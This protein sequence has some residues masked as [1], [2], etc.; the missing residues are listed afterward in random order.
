VSGQVHDVYEAG[1]ADVVGMIGQLCEDVSRPLIIT[2]KNSGRI[3]DALRN[4]RLRGKRIIS[5]V[6][7]VSADARDHYIGIDNR[8]A[9]QTAAFLIGRALGA[10]PSLAGVVVGD[11][12]FR[13][14]EDREIGFRTGLRAHFPKVVLAGEARG[15]DSPE[16]TFRAVTRM[17]QDH[18]A[19]GAI[20]NVGGGNQGLT[21]AL[22]DAG[23]TDDVIVVGHDVNFVTAP[24]CT[25]GCSIACSQPIPH[26]C[27]IR[28][29]L[30][31]LPRRALR[32]IPGLSISGC[33]RVSMCRDLRSEGSD[34]RYLIMR[35]SVLILEHGSVFQK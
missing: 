4:A 30:L 13:C 33:T 23:R 15:E 11:G 19:L 31:P 9:G 22:R 1:E 25:T 3:A 2:L 12:A 34:G 5:L 28:R 16:L 7:D 6:S 17:L 18:P 27:L 35:L 14:H 20:Y 32:P 24:C 29:L 8:A 10:R 21:A 26:T